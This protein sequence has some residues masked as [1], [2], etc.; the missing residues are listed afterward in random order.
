MSTRKTSLLSRP[1]GLV[2]LF[3]VTVIIKHT[4]YSNDLRKIKCSRGQLLFIGIA[5][6]YIVQ[7]ETEVFTPL[8]PAEWLALI[9]GSQ[10]HDTLA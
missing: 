4:N 6:S 1:L 9:T 7:L 2:K 3:N 8:Q 10:L 5:A